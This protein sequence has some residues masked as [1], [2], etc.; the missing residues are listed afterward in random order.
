[1]SLESCTDSLQLKVHTC[2][3]GQE[4]HWLFHTRL[5]QGVTIIP[6]S[7]TP[8]RLLHTGGGGVPVSRSVVSH[9]LQTGQYV[10]HYLVIPSNDCYS[11]LLQLSMLHLVNTAFAESKLPTICRANIH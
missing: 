3:Q 6:C 4:S 8:G 2:Q 10:L 1:M 7:D 5:L 11:H 9:Q